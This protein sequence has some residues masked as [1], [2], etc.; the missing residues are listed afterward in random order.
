MAQI[1]DLAVKSLKEDLWNL[2]VEFFIVQ[3]KGLSCKD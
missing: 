1:R 3:I 2:K